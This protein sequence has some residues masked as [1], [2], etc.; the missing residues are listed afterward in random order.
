MQ[1]ILFR[2]WKVYI[3][4]VGW[5]GNA[6]T[7]ISGEQGNKLDLRSREVFPGV[8]ADETGG[9]F[10]VGTFFRGRLPPNVMKKGTSDEEFEL[11]AG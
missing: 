3:P 8:F 11:I 6:F 9:L 10:V 7:V 1:V 2:F 4:A 5:G